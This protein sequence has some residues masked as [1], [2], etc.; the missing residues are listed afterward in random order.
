MIVVYIILMFRQLLNVYRFPIF[1]QTENSNCGIEC[2]RMVLAF[3]KLPHSME[4][5]SAHFSTDKFGTNFAAIQDAAEKLGLNC[6]SAKVSISDLWQIPLPSIAH[7]NQD[8]FVVLYKIEK[9]GY[10]IGDPAKSLVKISEKEFIEA[11]CNDNNLQSVKANVMVFEKNQKFIEPIKPSKTSN[12]NIPFYKIISVLIGSSALLFIFWNLFLFPEHPLFWRQW[13]LFFMSIFLLIGS[14]NSLKIFNLEQNAQLGLDNVGEIQ[15]S[16]HEEMV[17]EKVYQVLHE[18]FVKSYLF[19]HL[20]KF[21]INWIV[22]LA[23]FTMIGTISTFALCFSGVLILVYV[24]VLWYFFEMY[25]NQIAQNIAGFSNIQ[26]E[27]TKVLKQNIEFGKVGKPSSDLLNF[28]T[29]TTYSPVN[30]TRREV[31]LIAVMLILSFITMVWMYDNQLY[32]LKQLIWISV[33]ITILLFCIENVLRFFWHLRKYNNNLIHRPTSEYLTNFSEPLVDQNFEF[34]KPNILIDKLNF[35]YPSGNFDFQ[36][37]DINASIQYG[38]KVAITGNEKCGKSTL[39]HVLANN[40]GNYSGK[41]MIGNVPITEI[42]KHVLAQNIGICT[43]SSDLLLGT[44][45]WNITFESNISNKR[46]LQEV[47]DATFLNKYVLNMAQGLET[48]LDP[49]QIRLS[50]ALRKRIVLAR[51]LYQNKD[52]L[53]I[54]MD[55]RFSDLIE[56]LSLLESVIQYAKDK[57]IIFTTTQKE[58]I[59]IADKVLFLKD[60]QQVSYSDSAAFLTEPIDVYHH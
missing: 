9:D 50:D 53:L 16:L 8:H 7:W 24:F 22:F 45:A 29:Q 60:G 30:Q 6:L 4:S 49:S 5:V 51:L 33:G 47:I 17:S 56:N 27:L 48:F 1:H 58:V 28:N 35:V 25:E 14:I 46:R 40:S 31:I 10:L 43:D 20:Q 15:N 59:Q 19:N 36:L 23:M 38:M 34:N 37:K 54:D 3:N 39:I 52:I 42:P 44:L 26:A 2:L 41:I 18:Y 55:D 57:T 11:C 21:W 12:K 32:N 13:I